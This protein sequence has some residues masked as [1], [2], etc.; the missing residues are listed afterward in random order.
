MPY[1]QQSLSQDEQIVVLATPHWI[2]W[3][4]FALWVILAVPTF[5]VTLIFAIVEYIKIKSLE[6]GAT[7]KRIIVKKGV[8]SRSTDEIKISSIET[9]GMEQ[10]FWGRVFNYGTIDITGRG[11]AKIFFINISDPLSVK[12]VIENIDG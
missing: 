1:I 6:M 5:G 7:S 12:K 8:F 11:N 10:S 2:Y 3:R 4:W 9:I